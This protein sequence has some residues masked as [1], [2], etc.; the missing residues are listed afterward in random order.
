[1]DSK[2]LQLKKSLH[3]S[4]KDRKNFVVLV[5]KHNSCLQLSHSQLLQSDSRIDQFHGNV[6]FACDII[7]FLQDLVHGQQIHVGRS[8]L[9]RLIKCGLALGNFEHVDALLGSESLSE[10]NI[11]GRL[12]VHANEEDISFFA[13]QFSTLSTSCAV[14]AL[15]FSAIRHSYFW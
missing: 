1:V 10:N 5:S 15:D 6:S 9:G 3:F 14:E 7:P 12:L 11:I 13:S 8:Q 4:S 2:I